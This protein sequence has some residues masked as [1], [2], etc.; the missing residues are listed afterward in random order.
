GWAHYRLFEDG[1]F[2]QEVRRTSSRRAMEHSARCRSFF[3]GYYKHFS[4]GR[5]EQRSFSVAPGR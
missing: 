1:S 5:L 2:R 4:L 3:K